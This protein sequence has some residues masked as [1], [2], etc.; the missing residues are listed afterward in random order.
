MFEDAD[1]THEYKLEDCQY[2]VSGEKSIEI[3]YKGHL[4]LFQ[5]VALRWSNRNSY[6]YVNP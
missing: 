1:G 2:I 3:M 4:S 6:N 5:T